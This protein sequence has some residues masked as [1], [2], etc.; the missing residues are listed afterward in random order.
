MTDSFNR[1]KLSSFA[2]YEKGKPPSQYPFFGPDAE[3]YLSPDY[4]RGQAD[5]ETVKPSPNAV[6]VNDG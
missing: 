2:K 4:L 6:R 3:I 5:A 1:V